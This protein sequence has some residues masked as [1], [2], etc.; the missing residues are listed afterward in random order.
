MYSAYLRHL[1]D[2]YWQESV[3]VNVINVVNV[4]NR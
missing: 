4:L 1:L 3:G 2:L